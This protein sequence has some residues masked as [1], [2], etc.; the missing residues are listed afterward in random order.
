MVLTELG[1]RLSGALVKMSKSSKGDQDVVDACLKEI[2]TAL[3][4][5]DVNVRLVK[6][7]Q[8]NV[9]MSL[10]LED[11]QSGFNAQRILQK[12]VFQELT[13]LMDGGKPWVPKKGKQSVVMFVGLQGNGKTT[14]CTKYAY[15]YKRKGFKV[16][17]VCA[18][19]FRAGA[20]DQLKQNATKA[21]V[22]F[23]GSHTETDPVKIA[24]EGVERFRTEKVDIIIV[25]TS[26]RHKQ[27]SALFEEM[28]N[29][30]EVVQPNNVIYVMD[31]AMGQAAHDQALAFR[32]TVDVGSIIVTKMDGH[33]KGG[34]ALS[35]VAATRSPVCF[36][37]TGEHMD[38]FEP[39][40]AESF[41]SRLLGLGDFKGLMN[42]ITDV[43]PEE[44]QEEMMEKLSQGSFPLRFLYDQFTNIQE[45]GPMSQV[46]SMLP[47]MANMMGGGR[48][49]ES[50]ANIKKYMTLMDSMT[51]KELDTPD[52]EKNM[53]MLSETSR[54]NRIVRG[55]GR[56]YRD[57]YELITQYK[58]M[59]KM[60]GKMKQMKLPKKGPVNARAMNQSV[61]QMSQAIPPHL[62]K[63][64]GG[65][66]G[67]QTLMKQLEG[68]G[69]PG[70]MGALGDMMKSLG[71]G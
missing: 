31:G 51:T 44:A 65:M 57:M 7:L 17:M 49:K 53:K 43:I 64:I 61:Q 62:L 55:A 14:T 59:A 70:G 11:L 1:A 21:R 34:G 58:M 22:P 68:G 28:R 47:G 66:G 71:M 4:Q 3:L 26:G 18:D 15:H 2:C 8:T 5:A 69:G 45:M 56:Q 36:I 35:A 24:E 52:T 9:K 48:D 46:M 23:F 19:T 54:I 12:S 40:E 63:S 50:A 25:D 38:E 37:G 42:K 13:R 60:V 32:D 41:V 10:N 30:S 27:E 16:A 67:L 6:Q 39:F 33:A 29:I 20:F